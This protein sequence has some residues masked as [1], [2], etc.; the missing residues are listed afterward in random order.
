MPS[1][2]REDVGVSS[3]LPWLRNRGRASEGR[4]PLQ[5][6]HH[7]LGEQAHVQLALMVGHAAIGEVADHVVGAGQLLQFAH[8]LDAIV[9]RAD[10]LN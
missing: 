7:I 1:R 2:R 9:R 3:F 5:H 8:L 10:D 6:W 4:I